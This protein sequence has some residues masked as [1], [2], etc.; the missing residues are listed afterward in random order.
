MLD[1]NVEAWGLHLVTDP[2]R[3]SL[4]ECT[5]T[6]HSEELS[7]F[8]ALAKGADWVQSAG[9]VRLSWTVNT[10]PDALI[11]RVLFAVE[12]TQNCESLVAV[13]S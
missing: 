8:A 11:A 1:C 7:V 10:S 3:S 6:F 13:P 2:M 4:F 12:A 9:S 5:D